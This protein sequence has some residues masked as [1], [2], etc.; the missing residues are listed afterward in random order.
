MSEHR[1]VRAC[2]LLVAGLSSCFVGDFLR[3]QPCHGPDDC[4]PKFF[5]VDGFCGEPDDFFGTLVEPLHPGAADRFGTTIALSNDGQMLVIGAPG[6]DSA[7]IGIDGPQADNSATDSG[8]VYVFGRGEPNT[9]NLQTYVKSPEHGL[10]FGFGSSLALSGDGSTLAVRTASADSFI[11]DDFDVAA[12]CVLRRAAE[13]WELEHEFLFDATPHSSTTS[14][15]LSESGD[16]LVADTGDNGAIHVF[17]RD[18]ASWSEPSVIWS[19]HPGALNGAYSVAMANDQMVLAL[20]YPGKVFVLERAG[21]WVLDGELTSASDGSFGA[22]VAVA[23]DGRMIA[24][25]A[26]EEDITTT[27]PTPDLK[28]DAGAVYV[29]VEQDPEG[30]ILQSRLEP[31]NGDDNA[32]FG[33]AIALSGDSRTLV[34]T[35]P[36]TGSVYMYRRDASNAWNEATVIPEARAG[37][38]FGQSIA[39]S[40]NG[41]VLAVG[42]W[43]ELGAAAAE[44]LGQ[45][46]LVHVY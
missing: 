37:S 20:G 38:H 18:G 44:D 28:V 5:C 30:W 16:T 7:A 39:L 9:W 34:A 1:P 35:A 23:A 22:S 13:S 46:G 10:Y 29:F 15:A 8:A 2:V 12:L 41:Q 6:E 27:D 14:V 3:G 32:L 31:S 36:G 19:A 43:D 21:S 11:N 42:A 4:E 25:G 24:V 45:P 40:G 33:A 17:E 26:P